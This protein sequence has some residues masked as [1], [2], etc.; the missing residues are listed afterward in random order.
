MSP[1]TRQG[2]GSRQSSDAPKVPTLD[3]LRDRICPNCHVG[4]LYVIRYDPDAL[5]EQQQGRMQADFVPSGGAY[6]TQCFVCT[7]RESHSLTADDA[8]TGA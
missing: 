2:S 6:E 5:H 3:D 7:T 8:G 1:G 4:V